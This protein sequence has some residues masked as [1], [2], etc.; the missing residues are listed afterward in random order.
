M[1][2][3]FGKHYGTERFF[4]LLFL[5]FGVIVGLFVYSGVIRHQRNQFSLG[6]TPLYTYN[7]TW[8]RTSSTGSVVKMVSNSRNTGVFLL[9]K[10]DNVALTSTNADDYQVF[11]TGADEPLQNNPSMTVYSF[12]LTGYVGFY[13]TDAKGFSN[14]LY[15]M[16]IRANSAGSDA[17]DESMF[18][19]GIRDA[20][21][22]DNNQIQLYLN[23]G[24]SGIPKLPIMDEP[25]LTPMKIMCDAGIDMASLG[26][27]GN[28]QD[29]KGLQRSAQRQ[30]DT[31]AKSLV[32]IKQYRSTLD[33][34]GV[35]VPDLPYYIA[36]DYIDA[37]PVDFNTAPTVFETDM[38]ASGATGSS[39]TKFTGQVQTGGSSQKGQA[40][41]AAPADKVWTDT[42]GTSYEYKYFHTDYLYPGTANLRWQGLRLSDGLITQT[43]FYT[44]DGQGLDEAYEAYAAWSSDCKK[45]YAGEMPASVK[46]SSWRMLDG[47]YVDMNTSDPLERQVVEMIR[48]Y[49]SQ[50]N[51]YMSQKQAYL[52]L[53]VSMLQTES[54]IQSMRK[55]IYSNNG[56]K[57][58]NL[59]LY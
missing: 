20:S 48:K 43:R 46:Y 36:D 51:Q 56:S 5:L 52:S 22:R 11:L 33:E 50:V 13:F 14:Q 40:S 1:F 21:F 17:A 32:M 18:Y 58:Q 59:W 41:Q 49:V 12:G 47:S 25:G 24:A 7:Y 3:I 38:L 4:I 16:I 42:D 34:Q 27:T 6:S 31:M 15:K 35:E 45:E 55:L 53:Q 23:F 37:V 9:I 30:L 2:K 54:A 57:M 44:G 8:S 19:Q 26:I 28:A 29:F 10:N 39:G